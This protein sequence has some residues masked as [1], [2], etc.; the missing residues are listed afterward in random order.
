MKNSAATTPERSPELCWNPAKASCFF[1]FTKA[2]KTG[3]FRVSSSFTR[4]EKE[5]G[6]EAMTAAARR[7]RGAV[8]RH[9]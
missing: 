2:E 8:S 3:C 1:G 7:L 5:E 9:L 6:R 4:R